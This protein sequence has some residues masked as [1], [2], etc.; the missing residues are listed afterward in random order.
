MEKESKKRKKEKFLGKEN[1]K[2]KLTNYLKVKGVRKIFTFE[3]YY[4]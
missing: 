1:D 2:R 4:E 3:K